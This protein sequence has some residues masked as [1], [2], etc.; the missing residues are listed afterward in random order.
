[1]DL[2]VERFGGI[3]PHLMGVGFKML[4]PTGDATAYSG[5]WMNMNKKDYITT[6]KAMNHW[7]NDFV[8]MPLLGGFQSAQGTVNLVFGVLPDAAGVE[9]DRVGV[10]GVVG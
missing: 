3:P 2:I 10:A 7:A 1:M 5:L 9:Q 4:R 6:F 8:G